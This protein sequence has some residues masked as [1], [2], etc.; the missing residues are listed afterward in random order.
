ML[1]V[2][3]ASAA[4]PAAAGRAEMFS[5]YPLIESVAKADPAQSDNH[6]E[7]WKEH[8]TPSRSRMVLPMP[9]FVPCV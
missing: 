3:A 5:K 6:K 9:F 2:N 8:A 1:A 4:V 7:N